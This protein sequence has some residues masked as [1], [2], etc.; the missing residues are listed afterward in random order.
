VPGEYSDLVVVS[1]LLVINAVSSFLQESRA[2]VRPEG[3]PV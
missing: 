3:L 2:A 1:A